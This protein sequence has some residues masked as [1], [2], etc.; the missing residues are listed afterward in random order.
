MHRF[1][2]EGEAPTRLD[3]ILFEGFADLWAARAVEDKRI[4]AFVVG[5]DEV[6]LASTFTYRAISRPAQLE[7]GLAS[8][9]AHFFN[10]QTHHRGQLHCL[11]TGLVG[12]APELDL[13]IY[14]RL[15]GLGRMRQMG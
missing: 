3:A 13:V 15:N 12:E 4:T 6:R 11:L 2:G 10:H 8:A 7:Q 1:T 14:Q 9:L 5:L